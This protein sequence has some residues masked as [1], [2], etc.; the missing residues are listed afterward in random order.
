MQGLSPQGLE[1]ESN[2]L[3]NNESSSAASC[4]HAQ[5]LSPQDLETESDYPV[6]NKSSN[7]TSHWHVQELSTQSQKTES[8]R[9]YAQWV[10][11]CHV[12]LAYA[13]DF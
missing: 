8:D 12:S 9:S 4:S 10:F 1:T 2:Y 5:G 3:V 7:A 6:H 11:K 13:V